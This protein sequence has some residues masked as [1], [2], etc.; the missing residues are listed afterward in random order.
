LVAQLIVAA[1]AGGVATL[2][3]E[4]LIKIYRDFSLLAS[5]T[6]LLL[7]GTLFTVVA[8]SLVPARFRLPDIPTIP[9]RFMGFVFLGALLA[10]GVFGWRYW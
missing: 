7:V 4:Y 9:S 8:I 5:F 6:G 10:G 3:V 2:I 1:M